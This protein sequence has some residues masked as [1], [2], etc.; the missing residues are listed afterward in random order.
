M[1][2]TIIFLLIFLLINLVG[3]EPAGQKTFEG[4]ATTNAKEISQELA[5]K[6]EK[7]AKEVDR[8]E[9]AI[10]VSNEKDVYVHLSVSGFDRLFLKDIRKETKEK[11]ES[12]NPDGK[13]EVST[14]KKIELEL[15]EIKHELSSREITKK[16]LKED[17]KKV[18]DDLK[19]GG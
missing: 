4:E 11:L 16:Q 12:S 5:K 10:A 7:T 15:T 6:A 8:V 9:E 14:D 19:A 13:V 18:D 1:K 2:K 3:C 17:L